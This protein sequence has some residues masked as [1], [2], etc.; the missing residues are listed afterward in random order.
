[1]VLQITSSTTASGEYAYFSFTAT[2]G[3]N[4]GMG[5]TDLV[6]TDTSMNPSTY[7]MV[8]IYKPDGSIWQSAFCSNSTDFNLSNVP[9]TGTYI[10]MAQPSPYGTGTLSFKATLSDDLVIPLIANTPAD[11][12]L[13]RNGQHGRWTFDA[14]AGSTLGIQVG[15]V[16]MAPT[17]R[18]L[19]LGIIAPDGTRFEY[20]FTR[21]GTTFNLVNLPATGTYTVHANPQ[22]GAKAALSATL[23]PSTSVV[24]PR[25][26]TSSII[27]TTASG[28]Y[29]YF[30]FAAKKGENLGLG[31]T[32]VV[33]ADTVADPSTFVVATVYKPDG[34]SWQTIRFADHSDFN[35][36][37]C[38]CRWHVYSNDTAFSLRNRNT[39][40]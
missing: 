20:S 13:N 30:S 39:Q 10:V 35:L 12:G 22:D 8:T 7:A 27:S 11:M 33:I 2:R 15:I 40:L 24:V 3:E 4:V 14:I 32:D 19:G 36:I 1:M 9:V 25:G 21:S 38:S 23:L 37:R 16:S 18:A 26:G 5:I 17:D 29:A 34:S 6:V 28:Q 31:I